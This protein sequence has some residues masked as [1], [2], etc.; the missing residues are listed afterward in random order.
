MGG[1]VHLTFYLSEFHQQKKLV[2]TLLLTKIFILFL[3]SL[4]SLNI[5]ALATTSI[6][7]IEKAVAVFF[8]LETS[9]WV[10]ALI[11]EHPAIYD[12]LYETVIDLSQVV[13]D[14]QT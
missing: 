6:E 12:E 1:L 2:K 13:P 8:L 5:I 11:K 7:A 14:T 10:Y 4:A 3:G 9:S